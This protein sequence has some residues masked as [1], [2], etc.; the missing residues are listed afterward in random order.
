MI[1][2]ALNRHAHGWT[3]SN[4]AQIQLMLEYDVLHER[5]LTTCRVMVPCESRRAAL[6]MYLFTS[7]GSSQSVAVTT[8]T[9]LYKRSALYM[10]AGA[11]SG[12]Q[13]SFSIGFLLI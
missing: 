3:T 6:C 8:Q 12:S 5:H 11:T 2:R 13:E 7:V 1:V 4:H 10:L 9:T